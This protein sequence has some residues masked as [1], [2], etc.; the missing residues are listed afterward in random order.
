MKAQNHIGVVGPC[1]A[2]KSTLIAGLAK[3]GYA[4]RHIAQEHSYVPSMWQRLVD[5]EVLIFLDVSYNLTL[6]RR[7][8]DWSV[9]EY[10]EQQRRLEHARRHATLYVNTDNLSIEQVLDTVLAFL[11]KKSS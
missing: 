7:K 10:A 11:T 3:H 1:A 6:V 9:D 8:L 4:A 5:P 2:G